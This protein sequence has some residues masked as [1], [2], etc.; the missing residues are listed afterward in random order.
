M[1]TDH[2]SS[3]PRKRLVI[4][5]KGTLHATSFMLIMLINFGCKNSSYV[6]S[7]SSTTNQKSLGIIFV[8]NQKTISIEF[9]VI[10]KSHKP[11]EITDLKTSCSCTEAVLSKRKIETGEQASLRIVIDAERMRGNQ[12]FSC[13]LRT[14]SGLELPYTATATIVR[15][16]EASEGTINLGT[17]VTGESLQGASEIAFYSQ[18][19][20]IPKEIIW[21][22]INPSP[23]DDVQVHGK[24]SSTVQGSTRSFVANVELSGKPSMKRGPRKSELKMSVIGQNGNRSISIPIYWSVVD[25]VTAIPSRLAFDI[26]SDDKSNK[27]SSSK[28]IFIRGRRG[29]NFEVREVKSDPPTLI[30]SLRKDSPATNAYVIDVKVM[31]DRVDNDIQGMLSIDVGGDSNFHIEIP[32]SVRITPPM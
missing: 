30:A 19:S 11:I 31:L 8:N 16:F 15:E 25:P 14:D 6:D 29:Q 27:A 10:N 28:T 9:P 1:T 26:K 5:R 24:W 17:V 3:Y 32:Y 2:E 7:P 22:T 23:N 13:V 20:F 4:I 18:A 21:E 12:S